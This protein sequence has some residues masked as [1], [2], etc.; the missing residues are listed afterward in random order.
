M[1]GPRGFL[2]P[3][4]LFVLGLF[5][6]A[7]IAYL[8]AEQAHMKRLQE[9]PKVV[10]VVQDHTVFLYGSQGFT[11]EW[12]REDANMKKDLQILADWLRGR[13]GVRVVALASVLAYR[14]GVGGYLLYIESGDGT[15]QKFTYIRIPEKERV[16]VER[17]LVYL[18]MWQ[19][20]HTEAKIVTWTTVPAYG[21]GVSAIIICYEM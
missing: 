5:F 3:S 21:G 15:K 16:A 9:A 11:S 1:K 8:S 17:Y 14:N 12:M 4:L 20:T 6:V 2:R 13:D 19:Y 10:E 18:K 7:V